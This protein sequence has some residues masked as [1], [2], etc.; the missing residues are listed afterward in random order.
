MTTKTRACLTFGDVCKPRSFPF[1]SLARALEVGL[2][3]DFLLKEL[4]RD[5]DFVHLGLD[6]AGHLFLWNR[7]VPICDGHF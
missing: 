4:Q 5:L 1:A 3:G 7:I 2:F 6:K